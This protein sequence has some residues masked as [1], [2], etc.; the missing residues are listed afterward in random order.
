MARTL[1][2]RR[3]T[4]RV[5]TPFAG[6][7]VDH[8]KGVIYNVKLSGLTSANGR[9]YPA[10]MYRRDIKQYDRVAIGVDHSVSPEVAKTLG[11]V[12]KPRVDANGEPRGDAHLLKAHPLY[13]TVMEAAERNPQLFGFSHVAMCETRTV[14]GRL[15][16]ESLK[17]IE[18]V[19]LVRGPA[20]TNGFFEGNSTMAVTIQGIA[21]WVQKH[22]KAKFKLIEKIKKLAEMDGMGDLPV[23]DT[24]P[25]DTDEPEDKVMAAFKAAIME[26][27]EQCLSSGEDPKECLKD[28]KALLNSHNGIKSKKASDDEEEDEEDDE[29]E[30]GALESRGK[31]KGLLE[32]LEACDRAGFRPDRADLNIVANT[33]AADRAKV[34]ERLKKTGEAAAAKPNGPKSGQRNPGGGFGAPAAPTATQAAATVSESRAVPAWDDP[35]FHK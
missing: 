8:D 24:A 2:K 21:E 34:I 17:K 19:D 35:M 18:S 11:W 14:N 22:P 13:E 31:S 27:I 9:D 20:T 1:T 33:P 32:A 4:E 15:R 5:S 12:E 3:L 6:C 28:I 25:T 29:E 26:K 23:M 10:E 16:I 7:Q 30:T